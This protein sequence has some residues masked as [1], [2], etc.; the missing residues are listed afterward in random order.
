MGGCIAGSQY[1]PSIEY[2]AHWKHHGSI[3]IERHEHYLNRTWR[4]KTAIQSPDQPILLTVPLQK[5]KHQQM[6]ID[7]VRIFYE[8]PW[9]KIHLNSL[10]TAYGKTAFFDEILPELQIIVQHH[11]ETLWDLNMAI[12][13]SITSMLSGSWELAY[14]EG[15]FPDYTMDYVDLRKGVPAGISAIPQV[16]LPTYPQAQRIHKTH[17]PNLCILDALC[18]LGPG[19]GEYLTRYAAK[20]YGQP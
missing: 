3:T 11:H 6:R 1:I 2:F 8:E 16:I 4:N 12:L 19:T 18:H 13:K 9:Q 7:T 5:G 20:L 14:T 15:Y 17:Q 10:K